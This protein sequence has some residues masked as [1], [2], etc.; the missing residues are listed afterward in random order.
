M[1]PERKAQN[2]R[3]VSPLKLSE[4]FMVRLLTVGLLAS[5]CFAGCRCDRQPPA[6]KSVATSARSPSKNESLTLSVAYGS[7]KRRWL[8]EQARAFM[9]T[10]A[11]TKSGKLIQVL[12]RAMGSGEATTGIVSGTLMPHGFRPDSASSLYRIPQ[13]VV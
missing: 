3:K 13:D 6:P 12:G 7:E 11:K 4:D 10:A 5:L 1:R 8:E 2:S 9:Q